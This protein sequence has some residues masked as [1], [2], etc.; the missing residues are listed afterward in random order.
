M[1]ISI[2]NTSSPVVRRFLLC[3]LVLGFITVPVNGHRAEAA[4]ASPVMDVTVRD[5][6]ISARLVEAPL[7]EVLQRVQQEFGFKAHFH[8]DL[9]EPITLSL[10][11]TPLLRFLELLTANQSLSIVTQPGKKGAN[12]GDAKQVAEIWVL[13]RSTKNHPPPVN[14]AAPVI[15]NPDISELA[16]AVGEDAIDQVVEAQMEQLTLNQAELPMDEGN[17]QQTIANLAAI[18][19][20]AAVMAMAEFTHDVDGEIRRM[21]VIAIGS[22]INTESTHI[23]G[24]VLHDEPEAEIRRIA[25]QALGE[26]KDEATARAFLEEALNDTDSEIKTLARQLLAQ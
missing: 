11:D 12:S 8:G 24:Q 22:V 3:A 10:S 25:V 1:N 7:I 21:S 20:P 15:A 2:K 16:D 18:G 26:R 13:S 5:Q 4:T 23:L 14:S 9:T 19:D 17:K 6:L